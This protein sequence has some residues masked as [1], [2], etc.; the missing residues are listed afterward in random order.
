MPPVLLE[1]ALRKKGF[2]LVAGQKENALASVLSAVLGK[3]MHYG[4]ERLPWDT[5]TSC[6]WAENKTCTAGLSGR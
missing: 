3:M 4:T 6:N 5:G 2:L 1:T